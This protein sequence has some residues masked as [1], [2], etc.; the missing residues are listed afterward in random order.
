M[1]LRDVVIPAGMTLGIA[2]RSTAE[3]ELFGVV[4]E[5]IE[6]G[7][8]EFRIL[9]LAMPELGRELASDDRAATLPV[10]IV[11]GLAMAPDRSG[12]A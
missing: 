12:A 7:D 5:A 6:D 4:H 3:D 8:G 11:I 2:H 1:T 10:G 9:E